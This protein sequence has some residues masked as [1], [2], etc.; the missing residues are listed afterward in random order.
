MIEAYKIISEVDDMSTLSSK[1]NAKL[2][3]GWELHGQLIITVIPQLARACNS[4]SK[5]KYTQVM[6][7]NNQL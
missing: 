3:E 5:I 1:I 6:V 2:S 7:F 4:P